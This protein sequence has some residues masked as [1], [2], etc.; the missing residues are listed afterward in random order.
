MLQALLQ[1]SINGLPVE[2]DA[3]AKIFRTATDAWN[4]AKKRRNIHVPQSRGNTASTPEAVSHVAQVQVA[5]AAVQ[6]DDNEYQEQL[7]Q[8]ME[9]IE[10]EVEAATS[11]LKLTQD[12]FEADENTDDLADSDYDSDFDYE[13]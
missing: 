6:A 5:D 3:C 11:A 4:R 1:V 2:S 12:G 8:Q 9:T 13:Y 10:A 7:I